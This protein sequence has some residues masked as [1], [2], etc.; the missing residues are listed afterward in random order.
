MCPTVYYK[1]GR[2]SMFT[3]SILTRSRED[4]NVTKWQEASFAR[5][6]RN[7][8]DNVSEVIRLINLR[9]TFS[10]WSIRYFW[11][12]VQKFELY[13]SIGRKQVINV[14]WTMFEDLESNP[15]KDF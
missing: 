12:A 8:L 6:W 13:S 5:I 4:K 15:R 3:T 9:W 11:Y 2:T 10:S 7:Y 1:D 14:L